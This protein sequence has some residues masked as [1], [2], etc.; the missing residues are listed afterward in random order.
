MIKNKKQDQLPNIMGV[1]HTPAIWLRK[2]CVF[3]HHNFLWI[4]HQT[5]LLCHG[6]IIKLSFPTKC[7][8]FSMEQGKIISTKVIFRVI[9]LNY[10]VPIFTEC[11]IL[12]GCQKCKHDWRLQ[13]QKGVKTT[14]I[15]KRIPIFKVI[16]LLLSAAYCFVTFTCADQNTQYISTL[17]RYSCY[18]FKFAAILIFWCNSI[19]HS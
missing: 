4:S 11:I 15:K 14:K 10:D 19:S 16:N 3:G 8:R 17:Q 9:T 2:K 5:I 13:Y 6:N 12:R 1:W 18:R 7:L